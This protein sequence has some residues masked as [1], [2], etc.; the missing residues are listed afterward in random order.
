MTHRLFRLFEKAGRVALSLKWAAPV[1]LFL[2][3]TA[4]LIKAQTHSS[5]V[6]ITQAN[7]KSETPGIAMPQ[8]GSGGMLGVYL[9][10]INEARAKDL[11]LAEAR[12]AVVGKVEEGSPAA[13]SGLQEND[14]ILAFNDHQI[15]N[16]TQLY[17]LLTE[18]SAGV[19]VTLG[20]SRSGASQNLRVTLGQSRAAQR[21]QKDNLYATADAYMT[22]ANERAKEAEEARRRGDEK[23]AV[24]LELE[25][26]DFR[27]LSDESRATVD[28]DISEG[29]L[30]A[31]A[32]SRRL[33]N[34]VTAARYQL[35]IRVTPLNEQLAAF[36]K[37]DG[38]VLVNEVRV[39]GI[40]ESAGI[41]AGDCIVAV[42]GE[43][44][45]TLA[46]LNGL[47]D[48]MNDKGATEVGLGIVRDRTE[49]TIK[50]KFVVK[51]GQR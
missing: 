6:S 45:E 50:V 15:Y 18:S 10:D 5:V 47:V 11:K 38:G 23:E 20:I 41:K 27:R 1:L 46:D 21:T 31:S 32:S 3:I 24:R 44:V 29:R 13:R 9:G 42:N 40:A 28:K 12:G 49:L 7:Q 4:V 16:P 8:K 37:V 19:V 30:Q 26:R 43:R 14:V 48:R 25:S 51:P 2:T 39:G 17:R 36:F 22:T 33:S 34:N 35:G